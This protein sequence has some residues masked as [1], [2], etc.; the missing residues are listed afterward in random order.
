MLY[1]LFFILETTLLMNFVSDYQ[2]EDNLPDEE[3]ELTDQSDTDNE[4]ESEPEEN[5]IPLIDKKRKK[6]YY[7]DDE[8]EEEENEEGLDS[9]NDSDNEETK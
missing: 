5:D 7:M 2:Y 9:D 1:L 4:T 8:A 6:S 3:A